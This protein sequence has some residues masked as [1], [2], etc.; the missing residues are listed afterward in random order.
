MF[1]LYVC[2]CEGV[3]SLEQKLRQ[4]C[5][6]MQVLKIESGNSAKAVSAYNHCIFSSPFVDC[7]GFTLKIQ[8]SL[9][10]PMHIQ[11]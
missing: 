10:N 4:S 11:C 7:S 9:G 2:L 6:A 1:F 5:T 8:G 3:G